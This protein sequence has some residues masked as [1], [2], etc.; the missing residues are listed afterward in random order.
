MNS[1]SGAALIIAIVVLAAMLLLGLPFLF[2][3]SGSLSGTRS[4]AQGR[5]A[6]LG[7]DSAQSMGVAAGASAMSYRW[8]QDG[9]IQGGKVY[10]DDWTDLFHDTDLF[11]NLGG[12]LATKGL[13]RIGVN[14][15]EFDT[16][17]HTFAL[18]GDAFLSGLAQPD[19]DALLQ[20]YPT[21]VG[22]AIEDESGK[23][24]PNYLDLRAWTTLLRQV[25][26]ND[27]P[28]GRTP[29]NDPAHQQLAR[30]LSLLRYTL[31]GGRITSLE[32]LLQA[33]P[34][35]FRPGT[36]IEVPIQRRS[37]T[38]AELDRLRPFLTLSV[39]APA[40]GGM[41][42]LGTVIGVNGLNVTVDH[43]PPGAMLA[44]AE[45]PLLLG[46]STTLVFSDDVN[47]T[48]T[49]PAL[50]E[51][52][53][54]LSVGA[55][56][57]ID[58]PPVINLHQAEPVVR[59]TFAPGPLPAARARSGSDNLPVPAQLTDLA[60][61]NNNA[62][63]IDPLGRKRSPFDLQS[64]LAVVDEMGS[65]HVLAS[66]FGDPGAS[67]PFG[68]DGLMYDPS[69]SRIK[70]LDARATVI[71]VVTG[72]LDRFSSRGYAKLFLNGTNNLEIIEYQ[73]SNPS[74]PL[75][76][77]ASTGTTEVTLFVRRGLDGATGRANGTAKT[78]MSG[79]NASQYD[80]PA[81]LHLTALGP[82]EQQPVGIASA[83]V[84]T[85]AS[86]ATVTD[87]AG[88]QAAQDQHRV[89]AQALPQETALEA[90]FD[91]QA[92]LHALVAQRHG[93][94][95]TTYPT[96]YPRVTD[97]LPQDGPN[98]DNAGKRVVPFA[99]PADPDN[100]VGLRPGV[101]RT[102]QTDANLPRDW[103][104]S[105][106][107]V[108]TDL[109]SAKNASAQV[110]A[111]PVAPS[112]GNPYGAA[113]IT[114]EGLR[115]DANRVLAYSNPTQN[116][117]LRDDFTQGAS[118]SPGP[119]T[120]IR[121][122]QFSLWVRPD[123]DWTSIVELLDMRVPNANVG[124][125]YDGTI[126]ETGLYDGR[127]E[128]DNNLVSN[129]FSLLYDQNRAQLVLALNP[130]II[131]FT[132]AF[133]PAIPR[134]TYGTAA[135]LTTPLPLR[136]N[137]YPA[138]NPECL[139]SGGV[140]PMSCAT[141]ISVIQHR[142]ALGTAWTPGDWHLIQVAF[143]GN[144]PGG[145][146][147]IVDGL[148]GR[149]VARLGSGGT[150]AAMSVAGDHLT[151][152]T[153]VLRT[154]LPKSV[155]GDSGAQAMYVDRIQL[156]A[157]YPGKSGS[158]AVKNLLPRR[159]IVRIGNEYISYESID[160]AG[161]L[162]NCVRARRQRTNA[163][164]TEDDK[165]NVTVNWDTAHRMEKHAI[166]DL[167]VPGG[168]AL[169]NQGGQWWRGG[170][171]LAQPMPDGDPMHRY[172]TWALVASKTLAGSTSLPLSGAF[173]TSF[174]LRG[175]V[176]IGGT[177]YFYDNTVGTTP[178]PGLHNVHTWRDEVRDPMDSSKIL[179][180]AGWN[181]GILVTMEADTEV[182]SASIEL[183]GDPTQ[184][185]A[186]D[187][188]FSSGNPFQAIAVD[189]EQQDYEARLIQFYDQRSSSTSPNG[190]RAEWLLYTSIDSRTTYPTSQPTGPSGANT[191]MSFLL[192]I[193]V[194]RT[195][196]NPTPQYEVRAGFWFDKANRTGA[197]GRQR[198]AFAASDLSG[199]SASLMFPAKTRVI[200][201]Q[202]NFDLAY[203]LEAGDIVTLTP[204]TLRGSERPLQMCVRYSADDAFP[205][206]LTSPGYPWNV[207]NRYFAFT[208]PLPPITE[209][210][211]GNLNFHMLCW[212]C[213]TPDTDL[214]PLD[215]STSWV[216]KRLGWVLPWANAFYEN[217]QPT[218]SAPER[219]LKA[220]FTA[221]GQGLPATV[222]AVQAG[223]QIG[224]TRQVLGDGG[225]AQANSQ[226]N[227]QVNVVAANDTTWLSEAPMTSRVAIRTDQP[228]FA[229]PYG[230]VEIGG[231]VFA[232]K[233]DSQQDEIDATRP[234]NPD[235]VRNNQAWLIGRGLLGS[236]RRIHTGPELVLHLPFTQVA[237]IVD[238]LPIGQVGPVTLDGYFSA[239]AML[240]TS[241][242]GDRMELTTM[243]NNH[244]A[245]W[246]R[247]LYNTTPVAWNAR[248]DANTFDNLAPI[249]V[250][251]WPRYP[252]AFPNRYATTA[253]D[254]GEYLR[255]R[256]Y[257]WAGFPLR[258]HDCQ[259]A[260][261][262]SAQV[263]VLSN[264][265]GLFDL[266]ALG[267]DGTLDWNAAKIV[268]LLSGDGTPTKNAI[269]A[270]A[271]FSG[272][273]F[274]ATTDEV[275]NSKLE[276]ANGT[277]KTVD[278]AELRV[279]W[280]YHDAPLTSGTPTQ[281]LQRAALN[282]SRAPMIGPV[283]LRT[284]APNKVLNVER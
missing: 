5:L 240:L 114:P 269:D 185:N 82:R 151:M 247:G 55:A 9:V 74:L 248:P 195:A 164:L 135:K 125:A 230:I 103:L 12:P 136:S 246:L 61:L 14:R 235:P 22:L 29:Q 231:E 267:L 176:A 54:P 117:F 239:P 146:S 77:N 46:P 99:D 49:I 108:S 6:N 190:G 59:Q 281:W 160:D 218:G 121:G 172:Q 147:I 104:L 150:P 139:G 88:N 270:S 84:V 7:Q 263:T 182:I 78:F 232:Y 126:N 272:P 106:N 32:Q 17:N 201:V 134:E 124:R 42:D 256:S 56:A 94:L 200:P 26:I 18:P 63:P 213:W 245:S 145:M 37:L 209:W 273:R 225:N 39:L 192:N 36:T 1:R 21:V 62:D 118:N 120:P 58:P 168:F 23:L 227:T 282:G 116:G 79:T 43:D 268:R 75:P 152:P 96:P 48:L 41:I 97:V 148:V 140:N 70:L 92:T 244:T 81:D 38:R 119:L 28:D 181:A 129:R 234:M 144:Q 219:V 167:V 47:G 170:C 171:Q 159:G 173:L 86:T 71:H 169:A 83:G 127:T 202:T 34:P 65:T 196:L 183:D 155:V 198:T 186:Y 242:N 112:A 123:G 262:N 205:E 276:I 4:Y 91:K 137:I 191:R 228:V 33:D 220:F 261:I 210:N 80:R 258:F 52:S 111:Q 237:E 216:P 253:T 3:Q 284:R 165:G 50:G 189:P 212:P 128:V 138:V 215:T 132:G 241:R 16:R 280:S 51:T 279:V 107:G 271:T 275:I 40:R 233:T 211:P 143:T 221:G 243:P 254:R 161:G 98:V 73:S 85:L 278:G 255:C 154:D 203:V 229:L 93:S 89:I 163:S 153:L 141:P 142:Y 35:L 57:A 87:P 194:F 158:D 250:G 193:M 90:R 130:G 67:G 206:T 2:T 27:L 224:W 60:G 236:V 188:V 109:V 249:A 238:A 207:M 122:R 131:P 133:G 19:R 110:L 157:Y 208:E 177:L 115:L 64:P 162:I 20:R 266:D 30:T 25:G 252:S 260:S 175:F 265:E 72:S 44:F 217:Y 68:P 13:R 69:D 226:G 149:D 102:L 101:M 179:T 257:A 100:S 105:F 10:Q 180:P 113:D 199:Y 277:T 259:F 187:R 156:D 95:V 66:R 222:D 264:G 45:A 24:D 15:I 223:D 11:Y 274:T 76:L 53:K 214:S 204:T 178:F 8:Q 251:W 31:P 197:R 166:G 174:P 283:Y 184:P